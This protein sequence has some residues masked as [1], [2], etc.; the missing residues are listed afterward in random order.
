MDAQAIDLVKRTAQASLMNAVIAG[1]VLLIVELFSK[2]VI[3]GL[4]F[5]CLFPILILAAAFGLGFLIAPKMTMLPYG[6][7]K[8]LTA[9]W[10]GLG[11]V[12][13]FVVAL[14]VVVLV[15]TI[16]D[17]IGGSYSS[18]AGKV[19]AVLGA[20]FLG[21]VGGLLIGTAMAWLG[22]FFNLDKNPNFQE[23]RPAF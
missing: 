21:L 18:L 11:A 4:V 17:L 12:I 16:F 6:H 14:V 20:I 1:V 2:I 7:S 9:L 3:I 19:F 5:S 13:P 15:G 8:A 22:A 23:N 10:I